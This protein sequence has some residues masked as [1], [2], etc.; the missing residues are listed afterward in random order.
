M[1]AICGQVEKRNV[2]FEELLVADRCIRNDVLT[3]QQL[4]SR[5]GRQVL[6]NSMA[7]SRPLHS[8]GSW[9]QLYPA[10]VA[11]ASCPLLPIRRLHSA[12]N[13]CRM[14]RPAFVC[15]P[16]SPMSLNIRTVGNQAFGWSANI[17]LSVVS[18]NVSAQKSFTATCPA[19]ADAVC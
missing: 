19:A 16:S 13:R 1:S 14:S 11:I 18:Y 8:Q 3:F 12:R 9:N 7:H 4:E 5:V 6:V 2:H 10:A 17:E 15:M